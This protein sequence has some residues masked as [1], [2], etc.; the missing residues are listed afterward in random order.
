M[1]HAW[2]ALRF[3][4][5]HNLLFTVQQFGLV[6]L[7]Q[8]GA[9]LGVGFGA[10]RDLHVLEGA[11][12]PVGGQRWQRLAQEASGKKRFGSFK[13]SFQGEKAV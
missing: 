12:C 6:Q 8:R 9:P 11:G 13:S 1:Q 10:L 7:V 5:D 4:S 2:F 3:I